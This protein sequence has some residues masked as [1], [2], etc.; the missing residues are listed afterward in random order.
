MAPTD[1]ASHVSKPGTLTTCGLG[2]A[3]SAGE[4]TVATH[5]SAA[6]MVNWTRRGVSTRGN[7]SGLC[8]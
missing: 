3:A 2:V 5:S 8:A 7:I 1:G 4:A 6:A